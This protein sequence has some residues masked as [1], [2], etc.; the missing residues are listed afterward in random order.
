MIDSNN[1]TTALVEKLERQ[2][3]D[4]MLAADVE[5][6]A[7]L[8]SDDAVYIHSSGLRDDKASFI[9]KFRDGV[10]VYH[11]AKPELDTVS[12]L[13]DNGLF[14]SGTVRMQATVGGVIRNMHS[15]FSVV[16][17]LENDVWRLLLIQTTA[18]PASNV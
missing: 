12:A 13:G 5:G 4:L 14:G 11:M 3:W 8:L 18:I 9:N 2:R 7:A 6:S 16:W 17:R 1:Q 15:M 10:F